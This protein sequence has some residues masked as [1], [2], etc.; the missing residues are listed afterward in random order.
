M[1]R[2]MKAM[3]RL[4]CD[5]DTSTRAGTLRVL[6]YAISSHES[7]RHLVELVRDS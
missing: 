4:V 1:A 7:V 3:R 2:L 5:S 6:R